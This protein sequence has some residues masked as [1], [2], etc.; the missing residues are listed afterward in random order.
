M[1]ASRVKYWSLVLE[2]SDLNLDST[3]LG[4]GV[5]KA[6]KTIQGGIYG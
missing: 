1:A 5:I 4:R 6:L 3:S 2:N